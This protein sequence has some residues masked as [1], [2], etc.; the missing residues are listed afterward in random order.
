VKPVVAIRHQPQVPLGVAEKALDDSGVA[1]S[2]LDAWKAER[3]PDLDEVSGLIV[4]G[5]TMNADQTEK[6][7]FLG[8]ERSML[9]EALEN[10]VPVLGICLGGQLLARVLGGE[11]KHMPSKEIGFLPVEATAEGR[12]DPVVSPLASAMRVL[13][14]HEDA[15]ELP[16]DAELLF[17]GEDWPNQAFRFGRAYGV[18]FHF[19]PTE[20][21]IAG[22]CDLDSDF[23]EEWG[24]SKEELLRQAREWLPA[25]QKA[26]EAVVGNF[27]SILTSNGG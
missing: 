9:E 23:E 2:Y 5:G 6:Y 24:I 12:N 27:A 8:H 15:F 3:W 4:L 10:D 21:L 16:P 11:V 26:A 7:P 22:W 17:T 1:W 13:L 20:S 19:E 14:F 18:Q 25:Q